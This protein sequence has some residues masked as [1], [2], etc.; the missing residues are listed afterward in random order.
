MLA[1]INDW[2]SSSLCL[3]VCLTV[4]TRGRKVA[5]CLN[6]VYSLLRFPP[7]QI[8]LLS[9]AF[10]LK[11]SIAP[12]KETTNGI[13]KSYRCKN[14]TDLL[15][16][17]AKYGGDRRSRAGCR[18]KS[19]MCFCFCFFVTLWN[20]EV[21]DNGNAVKRCNFFSKQLWCHCI[22]ECL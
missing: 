8:S 12:S 5:E 13:K 19:V 10:S 1:H 7:C 4:I 17:H 2:L 22:Q 18:L 6:V 3:S 14:W 15:Y 20:Y 11:F 16:H 21:C 9:G